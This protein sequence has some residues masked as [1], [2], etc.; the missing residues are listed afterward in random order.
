MLAQTNHH[1]W[2]PC[3][4]TTTAVGSV[5]VVPGGEGVQAVRWSLDP[6]Q[7]N[8]VFLSNVFSHEITYIDLKATP[9]DAIFRRQK[10]PCCEGE[11]NF[12]VI[13]PELPKS[14]T[15]PTCFLFKCQTALLF[16]SFKCTFM[17]YIPI[18]QNKLQARCKRVVMAL[19]FCMCLHVMWIS[20][21]RSWIITQMAIKYLCAANVA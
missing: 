20:A 10:R 8:V 7:C 1:N 14:N 13:S 17:L 16:F 3:P 15:L 18:L 2:V 5:A 4:E 19:N 6:E 21:E 12:S 9:G 11:G